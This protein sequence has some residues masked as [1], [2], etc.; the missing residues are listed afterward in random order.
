VTDVLD[1]HI[2]VDIGIADR[3]ENAGATPG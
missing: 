3:L 1:D 2:D